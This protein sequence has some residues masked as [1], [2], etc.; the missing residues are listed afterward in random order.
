MPGNVAGE[1][2]RVHRF[3]IGHVFVGAPVVTEGEGEHD[4]H[5]HSVFYL[6]D[7]SA[8]LHFVNPILYEHEMSKSFQVIAVQLAVQ[9]AAAHADLFRGEGAVALGLLERARDKLLLGFLD[10]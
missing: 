2:R 5:G 4:Q 3:G 8:H 9:G 1:L 10:G 6:A 7:A